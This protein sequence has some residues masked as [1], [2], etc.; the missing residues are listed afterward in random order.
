MVPEMV[1]NYNKKRFIMVYNAVQG[2]HAI[3][4]ILLAGRQYS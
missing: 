3:G 1:Y 2:V 4:S